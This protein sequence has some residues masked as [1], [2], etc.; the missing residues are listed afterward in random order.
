MNDS[1][2]RLQLTKL[3]D[4]FLAAW[5]RGQWQDLEQH[6]AEDAELISNQH[7]EGRD[8][9]DWHRLLA[10]A[11]TLTWMRTSNHATLVAQ[12]GQAASSFYAIGLFSRGAQQFLFG[13]SVV[14]QFRQ[15]NRQQGDRWYLTTARLNANW[16][17][18]DMSL[19]A[20]WRKPP[21]DAGWQLGDDPPTIVSE[22]DSPWALIRNALPE[23]S[24]Q[25]AVR[26]L[27]SKYSWAIDQGDINLLNDCYTDD[28]AGVFT[29]MGAL[30][31][32]HEIIGQQKSFRRHWPWMQ[33]FADVL[34][35]ELESD[36]C[37]ARMIVGRIVPERH[38]DET[39]R[40]LYG[41]HY[42]LRLRLEESGQWRICWF[43]Y[44]PGWF[45]DNNI[46]AFEI[47]IT[48]A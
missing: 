37:Y 19:A 41:A 12:S 25:D 3:R 36:G 47:G 4:A 31:G 14:L 48:N 18:G 27:Y 15:N 44:R 30:Q 6:L 24:A 40:N 43:D 23:G 34:R 13:A 46:P 45:T 29:P 38:V 39:G 5:M 35:L 16:C 28:A 26:Q 42:Q 10:D 9:S 32:R 33:H 7:G 1:D 17:K 8:E 20:H 21:N 11:A 22:L 2:A